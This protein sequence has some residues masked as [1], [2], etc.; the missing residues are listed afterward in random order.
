MPNNILCY[1]LETTSEKPES[2]RVCQIA[3]VM[4]DADD[5][6][7]PAPD[8]WL[9]EICDPGLEASD[10]ATAIHG[11]GP[12]QW[13]G[14]RPDIEA[15]SEMYQKLNDGLRVDGMPQFVVAGHNVRWF[16][17]AILYRITESP[18]IYG[19]P[20]IDTMV[21]AQRLYPLAPSH[22]LTTNPAQPEKTG[23]INWLWGDGAVSGAHTAVGDAAMVYRL[24]RHFMDGLGKSAQEL[25]DWCAEARI[26]KYCTFGKFKGKLWGNVAGN[27]DYVP[28][29]QAKW[30]AMNFSPN[31]DLEATLKR[32]YGLTFACRLRQTV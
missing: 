26:V 12:E 24:V 18:E 11:I 19:L 10:G 6:A 17:L 13:A 32:H 2:C 15:L 8:V 3:A 16:D 29:G 23:L 7:A 14:K 4:F 20:I 30:V 5:P 22:R 31:P 1:D 27:K 9:D 21:A 28:Y 25:A